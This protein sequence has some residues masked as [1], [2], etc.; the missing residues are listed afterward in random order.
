MGMEGYP[1]DLPGVMK[2]INKYIIETCKNRNFRKNFGKEQTGT[3]LHQ[4]QEK[5]NNDINNK[6]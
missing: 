4:I 2:L 5:D 6:I 3:A 1:K